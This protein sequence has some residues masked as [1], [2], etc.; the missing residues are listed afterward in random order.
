MRDF[1]GDFSPGFADVA[2]W[3]KGIA[4]KLHFH[5]PGSLGEIRSDPD[6]GKTG[7]SFYD[8]KTAINR[9]SFLSK[10]RIS[11]QDFVF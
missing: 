7:D 5:Y 8:M 4:R 10:S 1:L 6:H 9:R 2:R 11:V 3:T